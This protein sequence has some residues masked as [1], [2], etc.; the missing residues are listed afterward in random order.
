[1]KAMLGRTSF[2]KL[3]LII[4]S[5]ITLLFFTS[6]PPGTYVTVTFDS[7]GGTPA[8]PSSILVRAGGS[9]DYLATS[10]RTGYTLVGWFTAADQTG[11]KVTKDTILEHDE[12]HTLYAHWTPTEYGITYHLDGGVN[13]GGNPTTYTITNLPINLLDPTKAGF[14]FLGW[15]RQEGSTDYVDEIPTDTTGNLDI[16]ANWETAQYL[17]TFNPD[18]GTP[19]FTSKQVTAGSTYGIL[20]LCSKTGYDFGGWYD[21]A[22]GAGAL[23]TSA[24]TVE[25]TD[26]QT[27]YAKWTAISYAITYNLNDGTNHANN[28]ANYTILNTPVI[29]SDPTK[30]GHT[31]LGWF[32]DSGFSQATTGITTGATGAKTF[33]A[34]WEASTYNVTYNSNGGA[35]EPVVR[36]VMFGQQYAYNPDTSSS[37]DL[38]T[39]TKADCSF[40]GWWADAAGEDTKI[41]GNSYVETAADHTIYAKHM[42]QTA[43]GGYV[44]YDKGY[45]SDGWRYLEAG[46]ATMET[47]LTWGA[48]GTDDG[49]YLMNYADYQL[50]AGKAN[51]A[52]LAAIPSWNGETDYPA[53]YC[54]NLD[55]GGHSDWYLPT[56][57]E[58]KL[59]FSVLYARGLGDFGENVYSSRML[60]WTSNGSKAS[61]QPT[62]D[63]YYVTFFTGSQSYTGF[64][65]VLMV[66][67][68]R[69]YE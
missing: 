63:A 45:A 39:S 26:D 49:F 13:N 35:E 8:S 31:F 56:T 38:P 53:T 42:G 51:T 48:T 41:T 7:N 50:G 2:G 64:G 25:I 36:K 66:R 28:P 16:Y 5:L 37:Q 3:N 34:K 29:L 54:A 21:G 59:I 10:T 27:L 68:I 46:P 61:N 55:S 60:Y 20:P 40:L 69:S 22:G 23:I 62:G 67:P 33:Y 19:S 1:M 43:S 44:F 32:T 6:C 65:N 30:T 18:G 58:L 4:A 11:V 24:S 15:S 9:Y 52:T 57:Q 17:I 47:Y 14:D 12:N